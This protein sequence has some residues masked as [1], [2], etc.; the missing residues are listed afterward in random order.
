MNNPAACLNELVVVLDRLEQ[1]LEAE[2]D[3]LQ[4]MRVEEA[5]KLLPDKSRLA[6]SYERLQTGL[7]EDPTPFKLLTAG[8]RQGL[9]DI[10]FRFR[11][12]LADN[13]R[14][15]LAAKSVGEKVIETIIDV[16]KQDRLA[17]AGYSAAGV[18]SAGKRGGKGVVLSLNQAV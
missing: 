4:R 5:A 10:M 11:R 15:I 7:A 1:V 2:T 3:C 13:E 18:I 8:Q 14:A 6:H 9:N 16:V 12:V 17:N